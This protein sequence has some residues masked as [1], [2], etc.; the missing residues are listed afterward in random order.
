MI[1]LTSGGPSKLSAVQAWSDFALYLKS[2]HQRSGMSLGDLQK[3]GK[4]LPSADGRLRDLPTSTVSDALSGKRPVKKDLLES[5]LTA[6]RVPARERGEVIDAWQR[7]NAL[8]GQGPVNAR[9]VDEASLRDLG[10]HPAISPDGVRDDL[11]AYVPRDFDDQLRDLLSAGVDNGCFV[12]LVGGSAQGKTRSLAEAVRIVVP[13][14]WLVQPAKTQ[15][16]HDLLEAQTERTVLW[17]DDLQRYLGADPPLLREHV[18]TLVRATGMIVV[19]TLWTNSYF[20]FKRFSADD[21]DVGAE[22]RLIDFADLIPVPDTFSGNERRRAVKVANADSRIKAAL[23][24]SDAGVTQVLA[25]A[26]DLVISWEQAPDPYGK[27]VVSAAADARRLGVLCPLSSELLADALADYL[28]PAQ[29]AAPVDMW[30]D[31]ALAYATTPLHGLVSALSL[32]A[33]EQAGRATGYVV[34]DYLTQ[35]IG[36][37]RR[38]VCPPESL[39]AAVVAHARDADDLR[40]LAGTALARM[41]Y[42]HAEQALRRLHQLG[43]RAATAQ[44]IAL[45]RRQDRW[46]EAIATADGWLAADPVDQQRRILR[47]DLVRIQARAE[48]FRREAAVD[49]GAEELLVELLADGGRADALR[50]RVADGDAVAAE[51]LAVLLADRGCLGELRELA[52]R[53]AFATDRF[54]ELLASL[55]REEELDRRARAGDRVAG[56]YLER[57]REV[58]P[59]QRKHDAEGLRVRVAAGDQGAAA[60]LSV[61]LFDAGDRKALLAEVNAGTQD[62]AE[63]YLALLTAKQSADRGEIRRIRQFGFLADGTPGGHGADR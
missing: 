41:R 61:M 47:A 46:G 59:G 50:R 14:W 53:T 51:D 11:P 56:L 25:A 52:D 44:L 17:L 45:L 29:R 36:K 19:G 63:R 16:I 27:A 60:E 10:V 3:V 26:P 57:L 9:R 6:W 4:R 34:A 12:V 30:L 62:A 7:I 33:H 22:G 20:R 40:R 54:A 21:G 23:A 31:R 15:E 55:G 48:Q 1:T 5:L 2:V 38:A 49:P 58:D 39:W 18:V 32:V 28:T 35:H 24:V 37:V 43:D 8:V 13:G 42:Q